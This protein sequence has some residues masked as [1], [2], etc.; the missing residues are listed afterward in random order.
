MHYVQR[1]WKWVH[2]HYFLFVRSIAFIPGI[3]GVGFLA[4]SFV[5]LELDFSAFGKHIKSDVKWISLQDASTARNITSTIAAGIISLLVFSFSMVMIL[6]NQ[7][8]SKMSNRVLS[9]L[10]SNRFQQT[11]LGIYTGTI[12]YAMSLLSTIRDIDSGIYVPALSIYLLILFTI[13]D[14]F[15]FIYF[16]HYIT[17]SVKYEVIIQRIHHESRQSIEKYCTLA[18]ETKNE[19]LEIGRIFTAPRSGYYQGFNLKELLTYCSHHNLLVQVL[20]VKGSYVLARMPFLRIQADDGTDEDVLKHCIIHFDFFDGQPVLSNP[21]NGFQQLKEIAIKALSPG[22]NDPGTA[23][24][25]INALADLFAFRLQHHPATVF[26]D[27]DG[28]RRILTEEILFPELFRD[29]FLSIWDY[30]KTDRTV[31]TGMRDA[32]KQLATLSGSQSGATA[33]R[34]MIKRTEL[35][36][37]EI[38]VNDYEV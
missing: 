10:I 17:E 5:M 9:S 24:L 13:T 23:Q 1:F 12:V 19:T 8:A 32:L 6:L 33:V 4:L 7:A 22:I 26:K 20:P 29:C 25:C 38:E 16:L 14:I 11:V 36:L 2:T 34:N 30:A 18:E 21:V 15:I 27:K 28:K 31:M 3:I 37:G 35:S